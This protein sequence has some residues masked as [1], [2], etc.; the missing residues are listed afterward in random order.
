MFFCLFQQ[1]VPAQLPLGH[2]VLP[3][4]GAQPSHF[5][6]VEIMEMFCKNSPVNSTNM[7]TFKCKINFLTLGI[8][9]CA[10]NRISWAP[11]GE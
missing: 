7:V 5:D 1:Q 6:L 4:A 10:F 9:Y 11:F 3:G 2:T 8:S